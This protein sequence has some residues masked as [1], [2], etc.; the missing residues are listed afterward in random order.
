MEKRPRERSGSPERRQR[1]RTDPPEPSE[2]DPLAPLFHY[3]DSKY[4]SHAE[5]FRALSRLLLNTDSQKTGT[6]II[7][8]ICGR[9]HVLREIEFYFHGPDHQDPFAHCSYYQRTPG[10]WYFHR[11]GT[12]QDSGFKGGS[13]QGVDLTF[14]TGASRGGEMEYGGILIRCIEDLHESKVIEGPSKC[15]DHILALYGKK[16]IATLVSERRAMDASARAVMESGGVGAAAPWPRIMQV[17]A[18]PSRPRPSPGFAD[19]PGTTATVTTVT[20]TTAVEE[21]EA[22]AAGAEKVAEAIWTDRP[23]PELLVNSRLTHVNCPRVGLT[24]NRIASHPTQWDYIALPYR[25]LTLSPPVNKTSSRPRTRTQVQHLPTRPRHPITKGRHM[26]CLALVRDLKM[27]Y[28]PVSALL[29]CK[30]N[31]IVKWMKA[32]EKGR[33]DQVGKVVQARPMKGA[34]EILL[35][36]GVASQ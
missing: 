2:H 20:T 17:L 35:V 29:G 19:E 12:N 9:P 16:S 28:G 33:R 14:G 11:S 13:Y 7:L 10:C 18:V 3:D 23:L 8:S 6:Y 36:M 32:Y 5:W 31:S 15:V 26:A 24:L 1:I 34:E 27:T 4:S 21:A 25:S 22:E 30:E